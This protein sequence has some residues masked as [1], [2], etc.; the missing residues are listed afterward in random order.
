MPWS[1][2]MRMISNSCRTTVGA[3]PCAPWARVAD[4]RDGGQ[5]GRVASAARASARGGLP[6]GD[7][8][9]DVMD[10]LEAAVSRGQALHLEK[11]RLLHLRP[12]GRLDLPGGLL[13]L[14]AE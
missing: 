10:L 7:R 3:R 1:R 14:F 4:A 12:R 8:R 13:R 11:W 2:K 6:R 9:V 5:G